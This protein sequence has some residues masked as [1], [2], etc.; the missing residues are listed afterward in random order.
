MEQVLLEKQFLMTVAFLFG[1]IIT[2]IFME[3]WR[4][5]LARN[6]WKSQRRA[7]NGRAFNPNSSGLKVAPTTDSSTQMN[8]VLA[9]TFSKQPLLNR[10]EKRVFSEVEKLLSEF[11][12]GWRL[13]AQVSLGEILKSPNTDAY[14]AINSKRVDMLLI[15]RNNMPLHVLEYQGKGHHQGNAAAR[16][17]IKKEAL[18][19]ANIGYHEI[20][21]GDRPADLRA[22]II[23]LTRDELQANERIALNHP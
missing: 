2:G 19:R 11:K 15:D 14:F 1:A 7:N 10:R 12:S 16:D 4:A 22:L 23:K 3:R 5:K 8:A 18:R 6:E 9:A 13:M 17:A 21:A 20:V